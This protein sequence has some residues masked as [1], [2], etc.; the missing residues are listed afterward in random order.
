LKKVTKDTGASEDD[1]K[2]YLDQVQKITDK[3]T[4]LIDQLVAEKEKDIMTV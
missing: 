4:A 1:L 2:G 3:F